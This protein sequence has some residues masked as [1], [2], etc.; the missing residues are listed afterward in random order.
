MTLYF[1]LISYNLAKLTNYSSFFF[2]RYFLTVNTNN[3]VSINKDS[4]LFFPPVQSVCPFYCLTA[5]AMSS[6]T[7]LNRSGK[8]AL[9][10]LVSFL[11]LRRK[12]SVFHHDKFSSVTQSCPALCNP[13]DCSMPGFSVHHQ[14]LELTQTHVHQVSNAIQPSH[15]LSSPSPLAFNL[16]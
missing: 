13:M 6:N 2:G 5:L 16:S 7:V 14:L 12:L 11:K 15:P 4:F 9:S 10:S 8:R 1:N 3:H